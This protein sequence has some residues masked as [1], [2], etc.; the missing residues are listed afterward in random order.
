VA[1]LAIRVA[2]VFDGRRVVAAAGVVFVEDGRIAGIESARA[3]IPD[4]CRLLDRPG[5]TVLPGLIDA[6]V[7]LLADSGPGALDRL[8]D[9][10]P[11]DC[12]RV[13]EDNLRVSL[14][15]G[16][17]SVRDLGD[18]NYAV[19]DWRSRHR[20]VAAPTIVASGP[21]ITTPAGH[22]WA[23]GGEAAGPAALRAAVHH[24]AE[25]GADLVKIMASGGAMTAG[26]SMTQGQY[27]VD[28]LRTVVAEALAVGLAVTAHAHP[29]AVIRDAVAAGV[30]GIEHCTFLTDSGIDFAPDVVAML[31]ERQ[32]VVCPTLGSTPGARRPPQLMELIR[33][34]GLTWEGRYQ[35]IAAMGDAGVRLVS[36]TDGGI[37]PGKPHGILAEALVQL[38]A[39][40][41]TPACALASAT[42]VAADVCG[43]GHR[44]GSIH[45]GHDADL[46]VIAGD[47]LADITT[48]TRV[49]TVLLHGDPVVQRPRGTGQPR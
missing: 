21:P 44:K 31:A 37:N 4:G 48:L 24:R 12:D 38:V 46:L 42:S 47:P 34:S 18:R 26:T 8:A 14:S 13:I 41:M 6:H 25:H 7:H 9:F 43:L 27:G 32:I 1:V 17:T 22:C 28:D 11:E 5:A 2:Q 20:G 29:L 35:Q 10:A 40:G 3:D 33:R 45:P 23:M 36:G 49:D 15:C 16:V 30:D 39:G 19:L